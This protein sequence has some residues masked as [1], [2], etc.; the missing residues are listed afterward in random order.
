MAAS[1]SAS[2]TSAVSP[3]PRSSPRLGPDPLPPPAF[4]ASSG[5]PPRGEA[6]GVAGSCR[7][8]SARALDGTDR[9]GCEALTALAPAC[10]PARAPNAAPRSPGRSRS[11]ALDGSGAGAA[12]QLAVSETRAQ[13]RQQRPTHAAGSAT[14][15][16]SRPALAHGVLLAVVAI[17]HGLGLLLAAQHHRPLP[18]A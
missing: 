18:Q 7:A 11:P 4:A 8:P 5:S 6:A 13:A 3:T 12:A 14:P 1:P 9:T 10:V 15:R 16:P 17:E 2:S